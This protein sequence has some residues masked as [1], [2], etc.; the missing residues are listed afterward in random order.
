[1][2]III[3]DYQLPDETHNL[4]DVN[5]CNDRIHTLVTHSP[6]YVDMWIYETESIHHRRLHRLIVGLDVEWRP[7]FNR[8]VE[9]PVATLQLCVG[10]RCLIFQLIHCSEIPQSLVD[11][12]GNSNYTF[13]G[14]GIESDVEK[15]MGD[16]GL[17]VLFTVDVRGLAANDYDMIELRNAGLKDLARQVLGKEIEK[18]RRVTMSRWDNQWLTSEQVGYACVDAFVSFEIGRVLNAAGY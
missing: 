9:N 17:G 11:F 13:V 15:L 14:V 3:E 6:S 18:P 8:Y 1:M 10:R 2:T 16:Y 5:F 12:L 4:Y 7:N